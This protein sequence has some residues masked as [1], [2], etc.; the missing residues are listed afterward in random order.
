MLIVGEMGS[1]KSLAA[2]SIASRIDPSFKSNPRIVYTV[3][4]F[5]E[6]LR[7]MKKG[8]ALIFDEC[9]VGV[10]AREW[11][12]IQNKIMS[13]LAQILRFKNVCVIFTTPN[14]R[15]IDI[16]LRESMNAFVKPRYIIEKRN[17]NVCTYKK[18]YVNDNGE[19]RKGDFVFYDGKS[20]A[21]GQ[22]I[23]PVHVPRPDPDLEDYYENLSI[24]KKNEK[25]KELEDMLKGD[26]VSKTDV[27][28]L[29][30]QSDGLMK[31][32]DVFLQDHTWEEAGHILGYSP[33]TLRRW[34]DKSDRAASSNETS[35]VNNEATA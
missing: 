4:D 30:K 12:K 8:Q 15:F 27:K 11:Q 1:G 33:R 9:G 16:N 23:N 19:V 21:A 34:K 6:T 26:D 25:M 20:G 7:K 18:I 13:V 24:Q 32:L 17:I 10:P 29:Q 31:L 3:M 28:T 22:I 35:I 5:L 2:V 14:I